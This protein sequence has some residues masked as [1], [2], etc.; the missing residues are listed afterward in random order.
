MNNIHRLLSI[1]LA[2]LLLSGCAVSSKDIK[3]ANNYQMG[4]ASHLGIAPEQVTVTP[5]A[6]VAHV[7][8]TGIQSAS[9]RERIA[10]DLATLNKNNPKL[11]PLR[12]SFR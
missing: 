4:L 9:D 7:T 12:W 5:G 10:A 2:S 3:Q 8:I 11:D 6:G 1:S